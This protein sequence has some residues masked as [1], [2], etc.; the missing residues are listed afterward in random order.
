[1]PDAKKPIAPRRG[2][3]FSRLGV[4]NLRMLEWMERITAESNETSEAVS[5]ATVQILAASIFDLQAR[6]GSGDFLTVDTTSFT[7]DT[8]VLFADQVEA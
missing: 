5:A 7:V 8:T 3:E 4:P 2:Q 1:M 6:L